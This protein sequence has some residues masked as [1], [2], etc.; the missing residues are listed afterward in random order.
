M[1]IPAEATIEG[2]EFSVV[3][4]GSDDPYSGLD[5]TMTKNGATWA[6]NP[7]HRTDLV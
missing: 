7:Q 6:G 4:T 2:I 1:N 3:T 5:T